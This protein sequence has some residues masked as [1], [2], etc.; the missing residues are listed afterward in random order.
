[1]Y[2]GN[3]INGSLITVQSDGQVGLV[4]LV[5]LYSTSFE[6]ATAKSANTYSV[7]LNWTA[8]RRWISL[9]DL[10]VYLQSNTTLA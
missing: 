3:M 2:N 1:M 6:E 8:Q 4:K 9:A 10:C 7:V 5:H